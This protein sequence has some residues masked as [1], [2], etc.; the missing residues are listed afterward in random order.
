M[1]KSRPDRASN[2]YRAA[3]ICTPGLE[4]ICSAELKQLG[5]RP[6]PGGPGIVEFDANARQLYSANVWLRTASRVTVR[7]NTF[8]ATD[9]FHLQDHASRIDWSQWVGPGLAPRFRI[10]SNDS[11]LYHTKAIAQRLHQV[12]L[13]P[14][15]GEP[16][17]LFVVR[18][19]RNNV[20]ISADSSGQALHKRPWRTELGEAPLRTTM[21]AAMLMVTKW[22]PT[23]GLVDPFCGSG[24]IGI[25]AA[26]LAAGMPPGGEREFAFQ[27]WPD[28]DPGSWASVAG[29]VAS[30]ISAPTAD[31][32]PVTEA[33]RLIRMSD[34]DPDMVA[35]A[36]RNAER[37]GVLDWIGFETRV[38]AHLRARTG[39]G[40]LMTNPPYGKRL[41]R[42]E[43]SGLYSRLGAVARERLPDYGLAVLTP[44]T[45]LAKSADDRLRSTARF[46]HGGLAVELFQRAPAGPD[47]VSDP[48]SSE[49][50]D[51]VIDDSSDSRSDSPTDGTSESQPAIN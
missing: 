28:F 20:T 26:L 17:Q 22:D 41:G 23:S 9:F 38:V 4:A 13:P 7:L 27:D 30:S 33:N 18:I 16:E 31:G 40:M 43:L 50:T 37:A 14:S 49:P 1:A 29:S 39:P 8:R 11:K 34:R 25:E 3:A 15:I 42:G 24:T 2:R 6:K 48:D 36:T 47:A 44:D 46:R 19:D 12:S 45:K 32:V 35:A 51:T 21:A 5:C 10:S